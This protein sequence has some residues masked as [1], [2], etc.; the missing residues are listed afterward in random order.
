MGDILEQKNCLPE[1][2]DFNFKVHYPKE[3]LMCDLLGHF[4]RGDNK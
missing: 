2:W 3:K 1:I 4:I